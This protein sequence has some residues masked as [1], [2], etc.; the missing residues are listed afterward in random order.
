MREVKRGMLPAQSLQQHSGLDAQ[1]QLKRMFPSVQWP[2]RERRSQEQGNARVWTECGRSIGGQKFVLSCLNENVQ[3][4]GPKVNNIFE[5]AR[6]LGATE[7]SVADLQQ[8]SSSGTVLNQSTPKRMTLAPVKLSR[9][10]IF[11]GCSL[12]AVTM[13]L[14]CLFECLVGANF[15]QTNLDS[16][17]HHYGMT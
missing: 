9:K 10:W 13:P 17:L 12:K 5:R 6:A 11:H 2:S 3:D 8:P 4:G 14:K 7:G 16:H 1:A 15:K